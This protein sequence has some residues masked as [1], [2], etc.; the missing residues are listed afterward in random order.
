MFEPHLCGFSTSSTFLPQS[1]NMNISLI[2]DSKLFLEAVWV[3][4]VCPVMDGWP[5]KRLMCLWIWR[6][7][8]SKVLPTLYNQYR[9]V[10]Q[11]LRSWWRSFGPMWDFA[12]LTFKNCPT[13]EMLEHPNVS[14]SPHGTQGRCDTAVIFRLHFLL[15]SAEKLMTHS[16]WKWTCEDLEVVPGH[17]L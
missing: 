2:G 4:A 16:F 1:K 14:F 6:N 10:L 11:L 9:P 13:A 5:G 15:S 12:P 3:N 17:H 8:Y 7:V